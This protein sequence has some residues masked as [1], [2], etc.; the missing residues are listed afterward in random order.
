MTDRIFLIA[1]AAA[2]AV[3]TIALVAAPLSLAPGTVSGLDGRANVID[4]AHEWAA[5][6]LLPRLVYTAGDLNCHQ[7]AARSWALGGNQIPVDVRM[8][9]G[10]L[11]GNVGFALALLH[12]GSWRYRDA[13]ARIWPQALRARLDS[14]QRRLGALWLLW[15]VAVVPAATDVFVQMLTAYES[16]NLNRF[17]TGSLL[18]LAGGFL[19]GALLRALMHPPPAVLG[20][21]APKESDG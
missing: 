9:A 20:A 21:T 18:G 5:L 4:H 16:T 3:W 15:A 8:F 1:F 12:G 6:P 17:L 7:M 11:L 19:I 2:N 10:F 13:A 14:P